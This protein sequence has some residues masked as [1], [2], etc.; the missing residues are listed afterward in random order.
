MKLIQQFYT[1]PRYIT[2]AGG[3]NRSEAMLYDPEKV[4]NA[5]FDL[6]IAESTETPAYR[7]IMNDF[8]M[9]LFQAGQVTLTELLENGAFPFADKLLQ[10]VRSREQEM[11]AGGAAGMGGQGMVPPE[12]AGA[13]EQQTNPA[14]RKMIRN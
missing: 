7:M 9:Q 5:E 10:S 2:I 13:L 11:L 6:S 4:R 14:V 8:L 12:I 3:R 1:E